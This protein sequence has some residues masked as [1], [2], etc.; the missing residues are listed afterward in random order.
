M[1]NAFHFLI[2]RVWWRYDPKADWF[3]QPYHW[4]NLVE[5]CVWLVLSALVLTR[6]ARHRHSRIELL[7][8]LAFLTFGLSDFR[9]A[10]SLQSWLILFKGANLAALLYLRWIVIRRHYPQSRTY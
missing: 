8:G 4:M 3:A 10:Y 2:T 9:E 5:G 7:Y 6:Y 1:P